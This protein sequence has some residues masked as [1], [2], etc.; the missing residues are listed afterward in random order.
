MTIKHVFLVSTVIVVSLIAYL[1]IDVSQQLEKA[2]GEDP[3]VWASDIAGFAEKGVGK[4]G[5][6]LFVGSSS[7]RFWSDLSEDMAPVPVI[8]RGFGGSKIGD[9]VHHADIL[10]KADNPR[11]IVIFVGSNDV[12][13]QQTRSVDTMTARFKAMMK[14]V[15]E[16]H[17]DAPV[18]YIA[19]TPSPLR[20]TIWG[21][22]MAINGA[23]QTLI[24]LMPNTH[25]IDTGQALMNNGEP[26]PDNYVSDKLHLSAKGYDIWAEII[27]SRLFADL[28]LL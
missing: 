28:G 19:I 10:F 5:S 26:D 14:A 7:I 24:S 16:Q 3:L 6:L 17:P 4:T 8:N 13:P 18:Y 20:W 9:V 22:A 15:R 1:F 27:R 25:Y 12:T 21:E 2:R 11:A 23:I